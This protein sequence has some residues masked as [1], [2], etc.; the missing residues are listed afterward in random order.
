MDSDIAGLHLRCHRITF[1]PFPLS[2]ILEKSEMLKHLRD[3]FTF[4]LSDSA[5]WRT[6]PSGSVD[7]P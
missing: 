6:L 1:P 5:F 3:E 4:I 7:L 2:V